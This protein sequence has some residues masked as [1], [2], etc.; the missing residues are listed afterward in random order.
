M[1]HE[2]MRLRICGILATVDEL[3]FAAIRDTL[4][5]NDA[6]CSKHLKTL[7]DCGYVSVSKREADDSRHMVRWYAMTPAGRAAFDAHLA[8]IKRIAAGIV[9]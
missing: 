7:A 5:M 4:G 2:P 6:A 9:D 3:Q 1:I 8:E